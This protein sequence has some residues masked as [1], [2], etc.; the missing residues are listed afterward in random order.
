MKRRQEEGRTL[1]A[2]GQQ[3]EE[4]HTQGKRELA[5]RVSRKPLAAGGAPAA[6]SQAPLGFRG[7]GAD[8]FCF[9]NQCPAFGGSAVLSLFL[10]TCL[11]CTIQ[12]LL[13]KR[14][15]MVSHKGTGATLRLAC[16]AERDGAAV[17]V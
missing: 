5:Q 17:G 16:L 13:G 6:A 12:L 14:I 2:Y 4:E 8:S 9:V 1:S 15:I 10:L 7:A 11:Q 3:L